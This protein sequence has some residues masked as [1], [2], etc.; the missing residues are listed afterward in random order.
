MKNNKSINVRVNEELYNAIASDAKAQNISLNEIVRRTLQ[1]KWNNLEQNLSDKSWNNLEQ[2]N[3]TTFC[4]NLEQINTRL[5]HLE[6]Y[7]KSPIFLEQLGTNSND[8]SVPSLEQEPPGVDVPHLEQNSHDSHPFDEFDFLL[9]GPQDI[10]RQIV[11]NNFSRNTIKWNERVFNGKHEEQHIYKKLIDTP[12]NLD[13][14]ISILGQQ[15]WNKWKAA[16][17]CMPASNDI[18]PLPLPQNP[19]HQCMYSWR[20]ARISLLVKP[21]AASSNK[22]IKK[23]VMK[24]GRTLEIP[25][26]L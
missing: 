6:D 21:S 17:S 25:L 5:Q 9:M 7:L 11:N 16:I 1:A 3:Y 10:C 26:R 8:N 4:S 24:Y 14:E 22:P 13:S 12:K 18:I 15:N 20:P 19:K 2:I 23:L